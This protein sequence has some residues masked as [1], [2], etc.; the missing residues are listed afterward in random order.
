MKT[1]KNLKLFGIIMML[2]MG[3]SFTSCSDDDNNG[4]SP[5]TINELLEGEWFKVSTYIVSPFDGDH[6]PTWDY[7]NQTAYGECTSEGCNDHEPERL[8][9][10]CIGENT[11][12][13]TNYYYSKYY[14]SWKVED[15][16]TWELKGNI[17]GEGYDEYDDVFYFKSYI[18]SISENTLVIVSE[19]S[20]IE[21]GHTYKDILTHTYRRN[22]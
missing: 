7:D 17:I 13:A 19:E 14:G 11:Y 21:D 15:S 12:N 22:D 5:E 16:Y 10:E 18:K 8:T 2:V 20:Y 3:M 4:V 1:M 9:I 6:Q